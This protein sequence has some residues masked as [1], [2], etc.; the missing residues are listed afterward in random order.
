MNNRLTE[1]I[2]IVESHDMLDN[3]IWQIGF[4][5]TGMEMARRMLDYKPGIN[6]GLLNTADSDITESLVENALALLNENNQVYITT[7]YSALTATGIALAK[8]ARLPIHIWTVDSP[9][10]ILNDMDSYVSG[11]ISDH[12]AAQKLLRDTLIGNAVE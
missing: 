1:V 10:Y 4:S 7:Q 11:V 8:N 5:T 2:D 6:F 9:S 12:T 3:C